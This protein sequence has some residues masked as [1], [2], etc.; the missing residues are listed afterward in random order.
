MEELAPHTLSETVDFSKT[1]KAARIVSIDALR[2]FDM[3]W[4]IGGAKF[5]SAIL[6]MFKT[7][8]AARLS[9][10]FEHSA[11]NGFTFY[12]LI[13]PLF[14]FIVGLSIPFSL[15][16]FRPGREHTGGTDYKKAYLRIIT[17]TVYLL[18]LGF[19]VNG[20]LDFEFAEMRWPGVLQRIAICYFIS[21][22]ISLH[23]PERFKFVITGAIIAAI[24]AGYWAILSF[25]SIKGA[26]AAGDL[27]PEGNIAGYVDRLLLPGRFCCYGY[28]DNEGLLSTI[29]A[30][31]T[32]L[33]G[34]MAGSL[35]KSEKTHLFKLKWLLISGISSLAAGIAANLTVPVNKILWTSSYVLF[36][37]GISILLLCLFYYIIDYKGFKR[38]SFPFVVIGLNAIAVYVVTILY[39]FG[40]FADVLVHGFINYLKD[41]RHAFFIF[42]VIALKWLFVYFLYR[43]KIF[44]KV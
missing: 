34:V 31:G 41:A 30:I 13:F 2:G 27:S 1:G 10:E 38:W 18:L 21:A 32:T 26:V 7:G 14:L 12:D 22:I 3:F 33:A 20:L 5:A 28:G 25:A 35:L 40:L 42:V 43:K 15:S 24:L 16:R 37:G 19:L 23:L 36:S 6:E 17:R 44:L 4:I 9:A 39:D 29:P 11:W 8:W